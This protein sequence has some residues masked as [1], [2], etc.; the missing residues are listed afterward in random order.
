MRCYIP[1]GIEPENYGDTNQVSYFLSLLS[2]ARITN[3]KLQPG[4]F[5]RLKMEYLRNVIGRYDAR[6]VIDAL[7]TGG[8]IEVDRSYK[9]RE[10]S[11]GYRLAPYYR[12]QPIKRVEVSGKVA[13]KVISI[14]TCKIKKLK[15]LHRQMYAMLSSTTID[16]DNAINEALQFETTE[17]INAGVISIEKIHS[18]NFF[19]EVCRNGR[20]H[21]N[22]TNLKKQLRKYIKIENEFLFEIDVRCSQPFIFNYILATTSPFLSYDGRID[23]EHYKTLT[24]NGDFY[25]WLMNKIRY[26]GNRDEFKVTFFAKVFYCKNHS[27]HFYN[28]CRIFQKMFPNVWGVVEKI[29]KR[30]YKAMANRLQRAE[31]DI[32]INGVAR[33]LNRAGKKF[34]TIHD[35]ILCRE[36]DTEFVSETIKTVFRNKV[37]IVPT[38]RNKSCKL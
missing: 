6:K 15:P 16:Y 21:T 7:H 5:V 3:R 25:D 17:Q 18:K 26:E 32:M 13:M 23:V 1:A 24:K 10:H 9:P 34:V 30:D 27:H 33:E 35:A 28:E 31:S 22:F 37:G 19:F 38:V 14:H 11:K 29:K 8:I 4:D 36:R 20:V 2:D 12:E